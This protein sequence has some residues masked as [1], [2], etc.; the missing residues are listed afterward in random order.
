ML[1]VLLLCLPVA[2]AEPPEI[3]PFVVED[4]HGNAL[5]IRL[6]SQLGVD[7]TRTMDGD[8]ARIGTRGRLRRFRLF[9]SA[10]L[11]DDGLRYSVQLSFAP[12]SNELLDLWLEPRI[13]ADWRVRIGQYKTPF[14]RYRINSFAD[15]QLVDWSV[16]TRYFGNERQIGA[17]VH[18]GYKG[19]RPF[20]LQAGVFTGQNARRNHG[21]GIA[22]V[23]AQPIPS[24]SDLSDPQAPFA[25]LHPELVVHAGWASER[26]DV[27][28]WDDRTGGGP[29]VHAGV[30][31]SHDVRPTYGQDASTRAAGETL[32]KVEGLSVGAVG[33]LG[34]APTRRDATVVGL[35]GG[36][37]EVSYR[38]GD[39]STFA[40]RAA[41]VD[42]LAPLR[43]DVA[44][45][46]RAPPGRF[47]LE[48]DGAPPA[49]EREEELSVGWKGDLVGDTVQLYVDVNARNQRTSGPDTASVEVRTQ[50]QARL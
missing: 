18:N 17:M 50:L 24:P 43:D 46:F 36:L 23:Y 31:A 6:V 16:V 34:T 12:R 29:R 30:S 48:V 19:G 41:R 4:A 25:E 5:R 39:H 20:E 2:R 40:V 37:V 1:S 15:L 27:A 13:A 9:H 47:D 35:L 8:D 14:T 11:L 49:I 42:V 10:K 21:V 26:M 22:D 7:V 28:R 33:Y 44:A 45:V 3:G 38:V 32:L